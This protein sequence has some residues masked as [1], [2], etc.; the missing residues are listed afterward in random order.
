MKFN[1]SCWDGRTETKLATVEA[2]TAPGAARKVA[3]LRGHLPGTAYQ[4]EPKDHSAPPE[5]YSP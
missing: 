4:V 5:S 3:E 2:A 1:V